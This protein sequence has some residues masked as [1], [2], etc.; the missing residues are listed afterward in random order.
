MEIRMSL[1]E[2][3]KLINKNKDKYIEY[4]RRYNDI[5]KK[6]QVRWY[7]LN[8]S[9]HIVMHFKIPSEK[10]KLMYDTL[11]EFY[12]DY[13]DANSLKRCEI[14]VFSNCP[15]WVYMNARVAQKQNMDIDWAIDLYNKEALKPP[16]EG[17]EIPDEIRLEK[18]LAFAI[19]YLKELNDIT[20]MSKAKGAM[21]IR[22]G[23][24][25]VIF[26]RNSDWV[27]EKRGQYKSD[28]DFKKLLEK[29]NPVKISNAQTKRAGLS[30]A[31][32]IKTT[33][34]SSRK[35]KSVAKTKSI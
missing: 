8:D 2:Y 23:K 35:T 9:K 28:Q 31:K 24:D 26:I 30:T 10:S 3:N 16:E 17:K 4:Q 14:K 33:K 11:I 32:T 19:I 20:L 27:M 13:T 15:S 29:F 5:R 6:I 1:T 7:K 22:S 18:G 25:L 12:T 21:H 34:V